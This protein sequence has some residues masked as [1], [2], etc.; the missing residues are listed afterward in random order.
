MRFG[1]FTASV[2]VS[3]EFAENVSLIHL[4]RFDIERTVAVLQRLLKA[5][6]A[7]VLI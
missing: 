5:P 2:L 7:T 1:F 6:I 3:P 4:S